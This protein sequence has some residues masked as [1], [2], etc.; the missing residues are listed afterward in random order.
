MK[1]SECPQCRGQRDI[2]LDHATLW[3]PQRNICYRTMETA[4]ANWR[5]DQIHEDR[6][7]HD[8]TFTD[9]SEHRTLSTPY[10]YRDGV[11]VW[12][13]EQDLTPDDNFLTQ[14]AEVAP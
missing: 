5:Y 13:S 11:T 10:H 2:C 4:A 1:R 14:R 7:Y 9:F 6:P 8:G 3:Y 12:V